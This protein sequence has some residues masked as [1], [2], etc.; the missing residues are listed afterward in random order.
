MTSPLI[1]LA[2]V[3]LPSGDGPA[4]DQGCSDICA[5]VLLHVAASCALVTFFSAVLVCFAVAI[6]ASLAGGPERLGA[7]SARDRRAARRTL[8][9]RA[10]T[11]G[12]S[13]PTGPPIS[14][15]RMRGSGPRQS[16]ADGDRAARHIVDA[17]VGG[18][19]RAPV[20]PAAMAQAPAATSSRDGRQPVRRTRRPADRRGRGLRAQRPQA[21]DQGAAGPDRLRRR[22]LRPRYRRGHRHIH[23]RASDG[24]RLGSTGRLRTSGPAADARVT[25]PAVLKRRGQRVAASHAL[26]AAAAAGSVALSRFRRAFSARPLVARS[27]KSES[28]PS[29][30]STP[31]I[32]RPSWYSSM[33]RG[34]M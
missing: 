20:G 33:T 6:G 10:A 24:S 12:L 9:N 7:V 16:I 18:S 13:W 23:D 21:A 2:P 28:F 5:I 1:A 11:P 25:D 19:D 30:P 27:P 32:V 3:G 34:S 15:A 4:K 31:A 8:T 29:S 14:R 17:T 26:S 22:D